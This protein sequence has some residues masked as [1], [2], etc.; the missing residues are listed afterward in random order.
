MYQAD[1]GKPVTLY[2]CEGQAMK[3]LDFDLFIYLTN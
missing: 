2:C 1:S 3:I